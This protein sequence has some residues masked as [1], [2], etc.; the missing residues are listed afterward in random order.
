MLE[1]VDDICAALEE[2]R[3]LQTSPWRCIGGV[4]ELA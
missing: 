1:E 3:L 2:K 4:L